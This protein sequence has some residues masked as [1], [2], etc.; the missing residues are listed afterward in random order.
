M[1]AQ[2]CFAHIID[3]CKWENSWFCNGI[4]VLSM[5]LKLLMVVGQGNLKSVSLCV[6]SVMY[7]C[8]WVGFVVHSLRCLKCLRILNGDFE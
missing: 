4:W 1:S 5:G 3:S 2:S 6:A 7:N 8:G